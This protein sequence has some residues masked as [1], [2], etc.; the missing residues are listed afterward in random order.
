[1]AQFKDQ[2]SARELALLGK[3]EALDTQLKE[4]E[5]K[6]SGLLLTAKLKTAWNSP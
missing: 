5:S 1:M 3:V 6:A 2:A 4:M